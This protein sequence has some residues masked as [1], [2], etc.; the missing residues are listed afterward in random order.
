MVEDRFARWGPANTGLAVA[1]RSNISSAIFIG[2]PFY[3]RAPDPP[4]LL[5]RQGSLLTFTWRQRTMNGLVAGGAAM[6]SNGICSPS[7]R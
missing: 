5:Q 4:V 6:I 1:T 3:N 2:F 7:V